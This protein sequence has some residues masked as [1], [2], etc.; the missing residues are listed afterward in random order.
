MKLEGS[1]T[2]GKTTTSAALKS[3]DSVTPDAMY[4]PLAYS[5]F[6]N[7]SH[8]SK[9]A[10]EVSPFSGEFSRVLRTAAKETQQ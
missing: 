2:K 8:K 5:R 10:S 3:S 7:E 6:Q 4:G 1:N 9:R